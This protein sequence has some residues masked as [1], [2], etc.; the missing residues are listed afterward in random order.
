MCD[1]M[2]SVPYFVSAKEAVS[3]TAHQMPMPAVR[4]NHATPTSTSTSHRR[5][6]STALCFAAV[7]L[8][9]LLLSF[10]VVQHRGLFNV[11]ATGSASYWDAFAAALCYSQAHPHRHATSRQE[12]LQLQI[13]V[14]Q[15]TCALL[16]ALLLLLR[17]TTA[18]VRT[19]AL[20]RT[21]VRD[22]SL[23]SSS[24]QQQ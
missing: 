14:L 6:R 24:S 1:Y 23:C 19:S 15:N 7:L 20:S 3:E 12:K 9:A 18:A 21:S 5:A 17:P 11:G 4:R 8:R 10:S 16:C 13:L 22:I 2:V